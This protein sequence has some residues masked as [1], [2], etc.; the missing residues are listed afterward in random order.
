MRYRR[1]VHAKLA[2]DGGLRITR[3]DLLA[4]KPCDLHWRQ[5][6]PFLVLGD[7]GVAIDRHIAHHDRNFMQA[8][9]NRGAQPFR[10]KVNGVMAIAI[11]RMNDER[12]ED[13]P[14][15]DVRSKFFEPELGELGARVVCILMKQLDGDEH[16]PAVRNARV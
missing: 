11:R 3:I 9:S 10:T 8:S 16:R 14:L 13:A 4:D 2:G 15:L 7:L 1:E 5:P 6:M 12:L